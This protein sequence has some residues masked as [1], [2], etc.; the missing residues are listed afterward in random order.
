MT[1]E[2]PTGWTPGKWYGGVRGDNLIVQ[3]ACT[4]VLAVIPVPMVD[5]FGVCGEMERAANMNMFALAPDMAAE[6]TRLRSDLDAA[7]EA[8]GKIAA[9]AEQMHGDSRVGMWA[10]CAEEARTTLTRINGETP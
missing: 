5:G 4:E 9:N 10:V 7:R 3:G 1:I 8:L 6:I 2:I